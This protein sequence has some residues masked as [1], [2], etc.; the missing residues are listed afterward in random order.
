[1]LSAATA[2]IRIQNIDVTERPD[3]VVEQFRTRFHETGL[4]HDK[5]AGA[6]FAMYLIKRH[7]RS[8]VGLTPAQAHREI[9]EAQ[10]FIEAAHACYD[11]MQEQTVA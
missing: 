8:P 10:L 9:E 1:M 2:L 7:G 5:Y 6:K 11:R 3:D 4:F